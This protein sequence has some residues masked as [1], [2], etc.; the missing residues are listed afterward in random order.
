MLLIYAGYHICTPG[1]VVVS[2]VSHCMSAFD[3]NPNKP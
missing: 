2:H 3:I 1:F